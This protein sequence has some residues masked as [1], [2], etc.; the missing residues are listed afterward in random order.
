MQCVICKKEFIRCGN[1]PYPVKQEGR[2]CDECYKIVRRAIRKNRIEDEYA[3]LIYY[4]EKIPFECIRRIKG[5]LVGT[6]DRWNDTKQ[7][8]FEHRTKHRLEQYD[9]KE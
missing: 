2:C 7:G 8:E 4:Y 9:G 3:N 5:F 1:N 6:T